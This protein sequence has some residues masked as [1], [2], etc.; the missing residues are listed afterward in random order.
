[1]SEA[2]RTQMLYNLGAHIQKVY[3]SAKIPLRA[4]QK[5]V[6]GRK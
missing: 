1:M 5:L 4:Y 2:M 3:R 6:K